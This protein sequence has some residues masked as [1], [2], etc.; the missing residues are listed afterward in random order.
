[1]RN[2]LLTACMIAL[3]VTANSALINRGNGLIYDEDRDITWLSD[4]NYAVTSGYI[5]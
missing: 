5:V 3:P 1:M 4:A 2:Y